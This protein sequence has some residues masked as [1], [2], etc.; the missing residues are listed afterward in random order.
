[1]PHKPKNGPSFNAQ[2]PKKNK[3]IIENGSSD[4]D[5]EDMYGKGTGSNRTPPQELE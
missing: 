3:V 2:I 1:M 5:F 4:D